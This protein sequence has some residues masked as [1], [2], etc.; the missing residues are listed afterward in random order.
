M[1][2]FFKKTNKEPKNLKE[3]IAI[4]KGL[5]DSVEKIAQEM[6]KAKKENEF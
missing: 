6:E 5:E 4:L 2:S 1:F 3:V